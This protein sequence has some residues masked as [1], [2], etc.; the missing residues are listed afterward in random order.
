MRSCLYKGRVFHSRRVAPQRRF[1]Y[2]LELLRVDLDELAL[3]Q[4]HGIRVNRPGLNSFY[5]KDYGRFIDDEDQDSS[6]SERL[7]RFTARQGLSGDDLRF[8]LIAQIRTLGV[9]FNPVSFFYIY[10]GNELVA[11]IAEVHNTFGDKRAYFLPIE[12]ALGPASGNRVVRLRVPKILHVSPFLPPE[13]D[14]FFAV[15]RPGDRFRIQITTRQQQRTLMV[16][17]F[18]AARSE[19]SRPFWKRALHAPH[20]GIKAFT[21]IHLQALILWIRR[22]RF[23]RKELVDGAIE[24]RMGPPESFRALP[25]GS[26]RIG[27]G[28][29]K[30]IGAR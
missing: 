19:L 18:T 3:L 8:E 12:P 25:P 4:E 28:E 2:R 9:V 7:R 22:A 5:E 13:V 15:S 24:R 16:A 23:Y 30:L 21:A 27:T 11:L 20:A 6:L 17:G 1:A 26:V 10:R 29:K 14:F